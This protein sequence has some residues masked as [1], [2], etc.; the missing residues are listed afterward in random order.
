MKKS[1]SSPA[2]LPAPPTK[3]AG[4][5]QYAFPDASELAALRAWYE[6]MPVRKAVDHY[7]L[8]RLAPGQSA[9]GL[10]GMIRRRLV[11]IARRHHRDDLAELLAHP[12]SERRARARAVSDALFS[13]QHA[14][15]PAPQISDD[16]GSW[17]PARAVAALKA[18]G[19]NTLADLAVRM[20]RRR[21]W[22]M[23]VPGLGE[24]G[25]RSIESFFGKH[26]ALTERAR[27]LVAS[28]SR[29]GGIV[30]WEELRVPGEVDGSAG[31]FR[32]PAATCTLNARNDYEAVQAWL[33]N[34]ES[35]DTRRTYRKE[36]ERLILWAI[37]ERGRA[38]SS[39][40][41]EDAVAYRAF[42]RSPSPR[43]RW[44]GPIRPRSSSD[45]RPFSAGL[46]APSA[47]HTISVINALFRWLIEHRYVLANP[48][49]GLKV[50]G[51]EKMPVFDTS[52]A[53]SEG[54]WSIIVAIADGLEWSYGWKPAAAKRLRFL[55]DFSYGTGLRASELT[56]LTLDDIEEE[57][58]NERWIEVVGK[59]GKRGRVSLPPLSW[60]ALVQYLVER[61]HSAV[62]SRWDP[63]TPVI[64]RVGKETDHIS[65]TRLWRV[66][67]R[68]FTL[69]ATV[70]EPDHPK[71]AKKLLLAGPHWMRHTH[72]THALENGAE[73]TTVKENLRHASIATTSTYLHAHDEKRTRQMAAAFSSRK[74][75]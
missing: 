41:N 60:D 44:V 3:A 1:P 29:Q 63:D 53:F 18:H 67:K 32:A 62:T 36:A 66:M 55:L 31:T 26:P 69:C 54:E 71:L 42:V 56:R 30:P 12:D 33:A 25:A 46:S 11:S 27:S 57:S 24:V 45:W 10:L 13:L 23:A 22:W 64:G 20:P 38:L 21:Q 70:I 6:G 4:R 73:L 58:L 49:A 48:F 34:H 39:L 7:L 37:I 15:V 9:R 52:H 16:I 43:E 40:T 65:A 2:A 75:K 74:G 17:L 72:A 35:P 59:G 47:A 61:G 51:G 14:A 8:D 5:S 68:F 19:I 50:R 28:S